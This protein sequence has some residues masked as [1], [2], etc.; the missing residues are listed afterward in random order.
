MKKIFIS[1]SKDDLQ[2][3]NEFLKHLSPLKRDGI[4]GTW[5]CTELVAGGNWNADIQRKFEESDIIL[6]FVSPNLLNTDYVYNYEIKKA[7]EKKEKNENFKIV[8]IILDYCSWITRKY[9]LGD[10]SAL[11]YT[12]KPVKD[13]RDRNMAYFVIV[14]AIKHMINNDSQ[15]TQE[16]WFNQGDHVDKI[17]KQVK[18]IYERIVRGDV[19]NNNSKL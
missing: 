1:Y 11:P 12:A 7:F 16:D 5:Y 18:S 17:S 3:V 6:Y 13:F 10:F 15:L 9:N 8:P 4:V 2:Y 14:E 19:D